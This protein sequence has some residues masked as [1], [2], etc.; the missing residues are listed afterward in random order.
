LFLGP[1]V[2]PCR[3]NLVPVSPV[4]QVFASYVRGSS[5]I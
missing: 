2:P 1:E 4:T 3:S 5:P